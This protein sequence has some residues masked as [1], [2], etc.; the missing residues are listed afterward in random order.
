MNEVNVM[1]KIKCSRSPSG[2]CRQQ[3][4]K[5]S[6]SQEGSHTVVGRNLGASAGPMWNHGG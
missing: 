1:V 4:T 3:A 6:R 5:G 2:I